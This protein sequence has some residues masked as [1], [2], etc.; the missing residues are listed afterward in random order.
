M[1]DRITEIKLDKFSLIELE[2][3]ITSFVTKEIQFPALLLLE[4]PMGAGKTTFTRML[5]KNFNCDTSFV[6]SPTFAI[7][8]QYSINNLNTENSINNKLNRIDHFDLYRLDS[9]D[10]LET[11]GFW[12]ILAE[13][14]QLLVVEWPSRIT[15][16]NWIPSGVHAY[17]IY[18]SK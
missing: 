14:S 13:P 17:R 10:D 11:S 5:A 1:N 6:N 7:H 9:E 12:E 16:P 4:G 2:N 15:S 3:W 18:L 8:Q